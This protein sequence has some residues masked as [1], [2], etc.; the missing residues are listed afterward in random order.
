ASKARQEL[1]QQRRYVKDRAFIEKERAFIAKHLSSQRTREAKGRRTRLERRLK[2]GEFVER[3]PDHRRSAAIRFE[4]PG[5][6]GGQVLHCRGLSK[7]Y[8]D[9]I[10]IED[11][12]LEVLAGDRLGIVGPN[13]SGKT[14]LLRMILGQVEPDAGALRLFQN[15]AVG[16][17]DQEQV[18]L[19]RSRR[20]IDEVHEARPE[21]DELEVRS[22]LGG[23]LFHGD[24]VFKPIGQLSGGEQ[25][26]VRLA[27]LIWS[28]P[29]VLI[30]DEPTNHLD[31]RSRVA[32]EEAL[33]QYEGTIIV[34]SHDR[35]F[36][37]R[38]VN[39]LLVLERA[40][41]RLFQGNYS[42]YLE[43]LD[44]ERQVQEESRADR[45]QEEKKRRQ[46]S[47]PA[48]ARSAASP[49]DGLSLEQIEERIMAKEQA[50]RV[51]QDR[52]ADQ[53]VYRDPQAVG[54]LRSQLE[55][56]NEELAELNRVWAER[57]D[58]A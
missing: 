16:Y 35:F 53:A 56:V 57:V 30:L 21:A 49:F 6:T 27:R 15:Q 46:R 18:G 40:G 12:N 48:R 5:R 23:F 11:L 37:D 2:A 42:F 52:F 9:K 51:V 26:R 20:L 36:L 3:A 47:R 10:L 34:V 4:K 44:E 24:E 58:G 33:T 38:T 28:A 1:T 39:R 29:Q 17:Y 8:G 31:I 13:G 55:T 22:Y 25:S 41:H 54:D 50:V 43:R 7:R 19:D 14:T 32:L 45:R